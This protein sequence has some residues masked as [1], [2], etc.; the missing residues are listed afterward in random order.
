MHITTEA[1][2]S[3]QK[4]MQKQ[5]QLT[6]GRAS[7]DTVI[8]AKGQGANVHVKI[9]DIFKGTFEAKGCHIASLMHK[10]KGE[11]I[12]KIEDVD[13]FMLHAQDFSLKRIFD[14]GAKNHL[15]GVAA[16]E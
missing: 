15:F 13:R 1:L 6:L 2:D 9:D 16:N 11:P 10:G 14:I 4:N 8:C 5:V 7:A 12:L 3:V